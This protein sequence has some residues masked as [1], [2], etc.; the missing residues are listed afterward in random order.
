MEVGCELGKLCFVKLKIG[1]LTFSS[2]EKIK[3]I[4]KIN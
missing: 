3:Q 1:K 2:A 4:T